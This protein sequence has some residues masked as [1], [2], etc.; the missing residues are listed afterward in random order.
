MMY[1]LM[2]HAPLPVYAWQL[3][4]PPSQAQFVGLAPIH[5]FGQT[6]PDF[7][8][9]FGI[10]HED[11]LQALR[12]IGGGVD[13]ALADRLNY[14]WVPTQ[15]PELFAR[16]FS[17]VRQFNPDTEAIYVFRRTNHYAPPP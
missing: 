3:K 14:F 15:R 13:Y 4:Y 6:P 16:A 11:I 12:A 8:I 2:Y 9:L 1:P 17:P 10:Q 5:Y 7:V